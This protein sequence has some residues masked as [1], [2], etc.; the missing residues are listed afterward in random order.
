MI[1]WRT[2][3][4]RTPKGETQDQYYSYVNAYKE[5]NNFFLVEVSLHKKE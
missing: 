3:G 2:D 1:K 4:K 5:S